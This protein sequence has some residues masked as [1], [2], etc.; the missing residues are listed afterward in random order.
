MDTLLHIILEMRN[1]Y[2]KIYHVTFNRYCNA[3]NNYVS[4]NN[5]QILKYIDTPYPFLICEDDIPEIMEWGGGIKE[6]T[7]VGNLRDNYIYRKEDKSNDE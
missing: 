2:M 4:N 1:Q 6:L 7:F 3:C 5:K